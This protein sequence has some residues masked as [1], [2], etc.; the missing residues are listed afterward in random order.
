MTDICGCG[1]CKACIELTK[2]LKAQ[3]T[4]EQ[5]HYDNYVTRLRETIN[6]ANDKTPKSY[7]YKCPNKKEVLEGMYDVP[8]TNLPDGTPYRS[9]DDIS[10]GSE[11]GEK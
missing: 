9:E 2:S 5:K 7:Q 6:G 10:T 11:P 1:E 8:I 3:L 4:P